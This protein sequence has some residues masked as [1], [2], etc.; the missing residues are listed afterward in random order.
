MCRAQWDGKRA[1]LGYVTIVYATFSIT[2]NTHR[3]CRSSLED[4]AH[5]ATADEAE[6]LWVVGCQLAVGCIEGAW[7]HVPEALKALLASDAGPLGASLLVP[8]Q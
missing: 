1:A 8:P 2:V 4:C 5:A 6:L 3:V 7:D